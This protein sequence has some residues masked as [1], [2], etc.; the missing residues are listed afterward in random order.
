MQKLQFKIRE[1]DTTN[2]SEIISLIEESSGLKF[3]KNIPS[4][5]VNGFLNIV[6]TGEIEV[7]IEESIDMTGIQQNIENAFHTHIFTSN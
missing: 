2:T 4:D 5:T 6:S 7:Y 1:E 3:M